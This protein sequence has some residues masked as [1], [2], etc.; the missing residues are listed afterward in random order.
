[1]RWSPETFKVSS[2]DVEKKLL[3]KESVVYESSKFQ[4]HE[5]IIV[6][7]CE[8]FFIARVATAMCSDPLLKLTL[9]DA[10]QASHN[11]KNVLKIFLRFTCSKSTIETLEQGVKYVQS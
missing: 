5:N 3:T 10:L 1:M 7:P 8:S 2:S 11:G 4:Q 9:P 6:W